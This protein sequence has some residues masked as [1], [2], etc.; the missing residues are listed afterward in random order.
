MFSQGD[1]VLAGV[2]LDTGYLIGL[3]LENQRSAA[4]W[5]AFLRQ[6]KE[7]GLNLEVVVKDAAGGIAKGVRDVFPD[8]EQRDDC[9]HAMYEMGKV[10]RQLEAKAY[11]EIGREMEAEERLERVR[12]TGKGSRAKMVN[13]LVWARRRC[14]A[15]LALHDAFERAMNDVTEAMAFVDLD[16]ARIRTPEEMESSIREAAQRMSGLGDGKCRRVG[17]YLY[18]R[19]PGLAVH[20]K[21][22]NAELSALDDLFGADATRVAAAIWRLRDDLRHD[23]RRWARGEQR[24]M[25][26]GAVTL[27]ATLVGDQSEAVLTAVDSAL[28]RRHRASSAIEGFNAALRPFLYV[29]KGVSPGFL[30]LFRAHHNLRTRRW[31]RH[32]GTSAHECLTGEPVHDWLEK[33]GYAPSELL[34]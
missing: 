6:A 16:S 30:E 32:K 11:K 5:A 4:E 19:A 33:L 15:A 8:A 27:L 21:A 12:R 7:Q 2:C 20:M 24:R 29:H 28:L 1:P 13:K 14:A 22:L 10:R 3:S 31:G 23:R 34:H 17:K 18:N 26:A 9:F 25:L